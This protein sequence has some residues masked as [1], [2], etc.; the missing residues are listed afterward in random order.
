RRREI[1]DAGE[2]VSVQL[3][4]R[5]LQTADFVAIGSHCIGLDFLLGLLQERGYRTKFMA[6][7]ST[8]GLA[9]AQRG[10]CD[11]AGVHLLDEETQQY[12]LPFLS[13]EVELL[14]GYGRLQGVVCRSDDD[15]FFG[16]T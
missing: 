11:I 13:A 3:L 14:R 8:A 4:G 5:D 6:V 12:N 9:A 15:R 1:V 2:T 7:G 10:E 16:R